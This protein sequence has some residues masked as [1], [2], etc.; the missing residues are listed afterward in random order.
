MEKRNNELENSK[1]IRLWNTMVPLGLQKCR[2]LPLY[3][4]WMAIGTQ[5]TMTHSLHAASAGF[6]VTAVQHPNDNAGTIHAEATTHKLPWNTVQRRWIA[7]YGSLARTVVPMGQGHEL[8]TQILFLLGLVGGCCLLYVAFKRVLSKKNRKLQ[9]RLLDL[10]RQKSEAEQALEQH[11]KKEADLERKLAFM[12]KQLTSYAF[13]YEQKNRIIDQLKEAAQKFETA[14]TPYEQ[15]KQ[16]RALKTMTK[17][18]LAIDKNW[19]YFRSFFQERQYGFHARLLEKHPDLKSN[20]LKLCSLLRLNLSIKET[21]N[22]LGI[23]T[24][25]LKTSRY[26]L[27]KKLNLDSK[28]EII[29]YLISFE[30]EDQEP[31]NGKSGAPKLP[32]GA[33][34]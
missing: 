20:D 1:P 16:L 23:S 9:Q 19:E 17:E 31:D 15:K 22:V 34:K 8:S 28:Y 13:S 26:R 30:R 25:S 10:E 12:D 33:D 3:L 29:D 7:T 21:A 2:C 27:R 6:P 24:G 11:R 5:L 4:L 14:T 18:N 32:G